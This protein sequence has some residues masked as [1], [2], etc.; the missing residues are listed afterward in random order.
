MKVAAI[1]KTKQSQ[2][3]V[4]LKRQKKEIPKQYVSSDTDRY[5]FAS[6]K[7]SYGSPAYEYDPEYDV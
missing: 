6:D 5:S 3:S 2:S 7:T 4:Q 1:D